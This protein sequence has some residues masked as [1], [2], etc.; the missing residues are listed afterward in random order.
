M[1]VV[2]T[3]LDTAEGDKGNVGEG[4]IGRGEAH[5]ADTRSNAQ[6]LARRDKLY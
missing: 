6:T 5:S 2:E 3:E 1:P 4:D